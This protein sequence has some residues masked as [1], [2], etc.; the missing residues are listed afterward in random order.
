M[1]KYLILLVASLALSNIFQITDAAQISVTKKDDFDVISHIIEY[2]PVLIDYLRNAD[3]DGLRWVV[4]HVIEQVSRLLPTFPAEIQFVISHVL[5]YLPFLVELIRTGNIQ[6]LI[7]VIN[8]V[9]EQ[10]GKIRPSI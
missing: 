7:W 2:L 4:N 10:L 9:I 1:Q 8:H 3:I 6:G 5:E